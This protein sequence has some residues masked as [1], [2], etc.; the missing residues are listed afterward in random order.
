MGVWSKK[1]TGGKRG[2][3]CT[4]KARFFSARE[5]LLGELEQC[6]MSGSKRVYL[7]IAILSGPEKRVL[8][9]GKRF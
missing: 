1:S 2:V 3:W 4:Y 7:L 5:E 6:H 9:R 8:W